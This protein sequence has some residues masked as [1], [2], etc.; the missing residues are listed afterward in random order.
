MWC[1]L[2]LCHGIWCPMGNHGIK[3]SILMMSS[4]PLIYDLVLMWFISITWY[5]LWIPLSCHS[6]PWYE[7]KSQHVG[8]VSLHMKSST[9]YCDLPT[10]GIRSDTLY[11]GLKTWWELWYSKKTY[12]CQ[13]A[14]CVSMAFMLS[15]QFSKRGEFH[16][17]WPFNFWSEL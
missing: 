9:Q 2:I 4:N 15:F 8:L 1:H 16:I 11:G 14:I 17:W 12:I 6:Y 10:F 3:S 13:L 7:V 5:D